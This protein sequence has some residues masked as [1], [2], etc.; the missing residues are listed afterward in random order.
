MLARLQAGQLDAGFFY[1]VE[2]KKAHLPTV[3]LTPVYKYAD[4]TI[5][6]LN[7]AE[8]QSGAEALVSLPAE[9]QAQ[10]GGEATTGSCRSSP[11]SPATPRLC[12]V[13]LRSIVGAG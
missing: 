5:T 7:N 3:P 4:Y 8:N 1:V 9:P 6:L 12:P 2:A 11:N 10:G 13:G